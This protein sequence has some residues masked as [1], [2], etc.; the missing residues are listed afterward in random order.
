MKTTLTKKY[1]LRAVHKLMHS[2]HNEP[3]HGHDY[4]VEVS[5]TGPVENY[6]GWVMSRDHLDSIVQRDLIRPFDRTNLNEKFEFSTGECLA[7]N[8]FA[9]LKKSEIG[10]QLVKVEIQETKKNR[11]GCYE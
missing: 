9:I 4:K 11:F 2:E 5:V 1:P 3:W 6:N 10:S 7:K 8:F